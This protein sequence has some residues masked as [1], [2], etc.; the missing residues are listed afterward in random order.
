MSI[1]K[2]PDGQYQVRVSYRDGVKYRQKSRLFKRKT[3]AEL[4]ESN[5]KLDLNNG[6]DLKR[7]DISF[8]DYF[9]SWVEVYK[10]HGVSQHTNDMYLLTYKHL[11]RY[12]GGIKLTDITRDDYQKFMNEFGEKHGIA[13]SRKTNQQIRSAVQNA[14]ADN[15]INRD[16][17][18]RVKVTGANPKPQEDKF[19]DLDE[20]EKLRA[21]L[22]GHANFNSI[23]NCMLLFQLETGCRFEEAA[24]MTWDNIDFDTGI[25]TVNRQWVPR[26]HGFGPTK[27]NGQADGKITVPHTFLDFLAGLKQQ[28]SDYFA[29][30]NLD[31]KKINKLDL[32]FF[33]KWRTI[34]T[35]DAANSALRAICAKLDIKSVSSHA[36]RHTHA[37]VLIQNGAS[38]PYVQHR[39]R[40]KKLETTVNNYIHLIEKVNGESDQLAMK[41]MAKGFP[42]K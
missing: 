15:I 23:S 14:L 13:T 27:G 21:Y 16:F 31:Y 20:Y 33:S 12:F 40:H 10:T 3:E 1:R 4:W 36:M 28:A 41:L 17:T 7:R 5:M 37:S 18:F 2:M 22:I 29:E 30:R 6:A 26:E 8:A 32:V 11:E 24:G 39:L 25:I 19:L 34:I 9:R 35:N 38:L 42:K